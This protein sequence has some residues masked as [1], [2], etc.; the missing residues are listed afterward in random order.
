MGPE[1]RVDAAD[2]AKNLDGVHPAISNFAKYLTRGKYCRRA[3]NLA[4]FSIPSPTARLHRD[5]DVSVLYEFCV[6][7]LKLTQVEKSDSENEARARKRKRQ[8][9]DEA[10]SRSRKR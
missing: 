10:R 3:R 4:D 9:D 7:M 6:K 1:G 5:V 2:L 8:S